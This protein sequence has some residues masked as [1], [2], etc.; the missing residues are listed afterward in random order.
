MDGWIDRYIYIY[1][2][3]IWILLSIARS[4]KRSYSNWWSQ[5]FLRRTAGHSENADQGEAD[6]T[7]Q[8]P[9]MDEQFH[10]IS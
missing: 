3:T 1:I 8:G 10:D 9:C 2:H 7:D 5:S 6:P 4:A